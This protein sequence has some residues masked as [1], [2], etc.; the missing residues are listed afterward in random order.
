MEISAIKA[1][2]VYKALK[3]EERP[4]VKPEESEAQMGDRVEISQR[5]ADVAKASKLAQKAGS[6]D[7][8]A[9]SRETRVNELKG[10]IESGQYN[11]DAREVAKS[12]VNG[13]PLNETT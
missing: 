1:Q 6:V 12:I 7:S 11:I 9:E 3:T 2:N 10:L 8:A 4:P 13:R 5:G